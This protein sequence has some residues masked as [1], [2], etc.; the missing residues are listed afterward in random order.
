MALKGLSLLVALVKALTVSVHL[1][2]IAVISYREL[3]PSCP[4]QISNA[5]S[6]L[7]LLHLSI[8]HHV[9]RLELCPV[10]PWVDPSTP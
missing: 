7:R 3:K 10:N 8:V 9:D 6:D 5:L 2:V 4:S 1:G